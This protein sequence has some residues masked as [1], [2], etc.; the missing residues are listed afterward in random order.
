[1]SPWPFVLLLPT[2]PILALTFSPLEAFIFASNRT[3]LSSFFLPGSPDFLY[4]SLLRLIDAGQIASPEYQSMRSAFDSQGD[5]KRVSR[6]DLRTLLK[7]WELTLEPLEQKA[8]LEEINRKYFMC[9][10]SGGAKSSQTGTGQTFPSDLPTLDT[11]IPSTAYTDYWSFSSLKPAALELLDVSKLSDQV[12]PQ[13]LERAEI[14]AAEGVAERVSEYLKLYHVSGVVG[15]FRKMTVRQLERLAELRVS[16]KSESSW[17]TSLLSK[18]HPV[19]SGLPYSSLQLQLQRALTTVQALA[20][21]PGL[22]KELLFR[23]LLVGLSTN[24]HQEV[25]F[26]RYLELRRQ[27]RYFWSS[28]FTPIDQSLGSLSDWELIQEYSSLY[29][30]NNPQAQTVYSPLLESS[31]LTFL[32]ARANIL[33]G[34]DPALYALSAA[35]LNSLAELTELEFERSNAQFFAASDPVSLKI[36]RKNVRKL[37]ISLIEFSAEAYY[38]RNLQAIPQD[39]SLDGVVAKVEMTRNYMESAFLRTVETLDLPELQGQTGF[40]VVEITGAGLSVRAW[41]KKGSLRLTAT[42]VPTGLQV[43]IYTETGEIAANSGLILDGKRYSA[44]GQDP[45]MLPFAQT[46]CTKPVVLV[47]AGRAELLPSF[48]HESEDYSVKIAVSVQQEGLLS[49]HRAQVGVAAKAYVNEAEMDLGRLEKTQIRAVMTDI[50]GLLTSQVFPSP[51]AS[52]VLDLDLPEGLRTLRIEFT[53]QV[54]HYNTAK[55]Q[56]ISASHSIQAND[57][58]YAP[59]TFDLY[60]QSTLERGYIVK[61]LG[62]NGE[63]VPNT[64]VDISLETIYA[65]NSLQITLQTD[66]SGTIRLGTLK[67]IAVLR[68]TAR[69]N[70]PVSRS[71]TIMSHQYQVSYPARLYLLDSENLDLPVIEGGIRLQAGLV[72]LAGPEE[73][74]DYTELYTVKG[75][76]SVSALQEGEYVVRLPGKLGVEQVRVTVLKGKRVEKGL[77]S[78]EKGLFPDTTALVPLG[79]TALTAHPASLTL[80]LSGSAAG[81]QVLLLLRHFQDQ[82]PV[83]RFLQHRSLFP[84]LSSAFPAAPILS[85]YLRSRFLD[86]ETRYILDRKTAS[87]KLGIG[88]PLPSLLLRPQLVEETN[89][90]VQTP[91]PGTPYAPPSPAPQSPVSDDSSPSD[92]REMEE[93]PGLYYD[94]LA[95]EGVIVEQ[96]CEATGQ[97]VLPVPAVG[98]YSLAEVLIRTKSSIS[99]RLF[100]LPESALGLKSQTLP[101]SLSF[102]QPHAEIRRISTLR[103][104]DRIRIHDI[105]TSSFAVIDSVGRLLSVLLQLGQT[106][107]S[108]PAQAEEWLFLGN[109]AEYEKQEKERIYSEKAGNELNLFLYYKDPAF[110][111]SV[112]QPFLTNKLQKT[113]LDDYLLGNSLEKYL[114][115]QAVLQLNPAEQA[116]L[117]SR[118]NNTRLQGLLSDQSQARA[119]TPQQSKWLFDAVMRFSQGD[120]SMQSTE[121]PVAQPE[122]AAEPLP[123]PEAEEAMPFADAGSTTGVPPSAPAS[124]PKSRPYFQQVDSTKEYMETSY[125]VQ[126]SHVALA[127]WAQVARTD[128][129]LL[130]ETVLT[131]YNS[132]TEAILALALTDLPWTAAHRP[133][134]PMGAGAEMQVTS[135]CLMLHRDVQAVSSEP[136]E[137]LAAA[138]YYSEPGV[139]SDYR[140]QEFLQGRAYTSQVVLTNL[141]SRLLHLDLLMQ[142]PQGSIPLASFQSLQVQSLSLPAYST[143]VAVITFYFPLAGNFTHSPA[144]VSIGE[145]VVKSTIGREMLVKAV[146]TELNLDSFRDIARAGNKTAVLQFLQTKNVHEEELAVDYRELDWLLVDGNFFPLVTEVLRKRLV[147]VPSVWCF[148]LLHSTLPELPELLSST[149]SI[150]TTLGAYFHSQLITTAPVFPYREYFPLIN[151]RAHSLG[152]QARITNDQ[153]RNTY[154]GWLEHMGEK[155]DMEDGDRLCMAQYMVLQG[156]FGLANDLVN[157]VAAGYCPLQRDYMRAYLNVTA[158][159]EVLPGYTV[160]PILPWRQRF[161]AINDHILEAETTWRPLDDPIVEV[162]VVQDTVH[163]LAEG[164]TTASIRL[165]PIN[166]EVLFSRSPF[167]Q[168][169]SEAYSYT[170]PVFTQTLNLTANQ[171]TIY[172]L[173]P[174]Y[175]RSNQYIV[176]EVAGQ[177]YTHLS[178]SSSLHVQ[179]FELQGELKVSNDLLKAV[180]GAYVKVYAKKGDGTCGFFKDGYTDIR[181]RFDYATLSTRELDGVTRFGILVADDTLGATVLEASAPPHSS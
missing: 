132:V 28:Y 26:K 67:E 41:V 143:S 115:M 172:S 2:L 101:T 54:Y 81:A 97:V 169:D 167:L 152:S 177:E 35:D 165:H 7:R 43:Q 65:L 178:L 9:D 49:G 12:L 50:T 129:V 45:V 55:Y 171:E 8:I 52:C 117:A 116:L 73:V 34:A 72:S 159:K 20:T 79:I 164:V 92:L 175:R 150:A 104:N 149:P 39:L 77:I 95:E 93:S 99:Q 91:Q 170:A 142:V 15:A 6:V 123:V 80:T 146:E 83:P 112:V 14:A 134:L 24:Q 38:R 40:F 87:D 174:A 181:G 31:E 161:R 141:S 63:T 133:F 158:A 105:S 13:Y 66:G 71:W 100:S 166:L 36:R 122:V 58:S 154:E 107:D 69:G 113:F 153:F 106:T 25:H 32:V 96:T 82:S 176:V 118:T 90:E 76:V 157:K 173:P 168:H 42:S 94:F 33:G 103:P 137:E 56:G 145:K 162:K 110:F 85:T 98:H 62:K 16:L 47:A 108:I 17:L 125:L 119:S 29:F 130:S 30:L 51:S 27:N 1:M 3:D 160:Y 163:I 109:W 57:Q 44:T 19:E 4:F 84:R 120:F 102:S 75:G 156:R 139:S 131:A 53:A 74:K 147:Y 121:Q 144:W 124:Q 140:P 64:I 126:P 59:A 61:A 128:S 138:Q 22:E 111:T 60:I 89:T 23:L 180:A 148:S 21:S 11:S 10:I 88:Y 127:F 78:C 46:Q 135:N 37:T 48:L 155:G 86:D 70:P 151:A 136:S 114:P 179:S 18:K 5:V 68:A